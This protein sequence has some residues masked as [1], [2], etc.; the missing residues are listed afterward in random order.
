MDHGAPG[1]HTGWSRALRRGLKTGTGATFAVILLEMLVL[2]TLSTGKYYHL[3][4]AASAIL[5]GLVWLPL[6][7]K[8]V[9]GAVAIVF[10]I[11]IP[12]YFLGAKRA[13]SPE[14]HAGGDARRRWWILNALCALPLAIILASFEHSWDAGVSLGV[15]R[16]A[17]FLLTPLLWLGVAASWIGL[18]ALSSRAVSRWGAFLLLAGL[19]LTF[20]LDAGVASR[21][22]APLLPATLSL[23]RLLLSLWGIELLNFPS[24]IEGF[25]VVGTPGFQVEINPP[26]AG[27]QGILLSLILVGVCL[28]ALRPQVTISRL[29]V[30]LLASAAALYVLN[31]L[32]IALLIVIGSSYSPEVAVMGFH[33]NFGLVSAIVVSLVS[34][35]LLVPSSRN[36]ASASASAGIS[37]EIFSRE[38]LLRDVDFLVPLTLLL[39]TS[40]LTGLLTGSFNW[41]YPVSVTAATMGLFFIRSRVSAELGEGRLLAVIGG[42][43]AFVVWI[44]LIDDD[45][46]VS[47]AFQETIFSAPLWLA[48]PWLVVRILGSVVIVP[49]AEELA[50]RGFGM[51]AATLIFGS[52]LRGAWPSLAALLMTSAAYG[53]VHS[54]IVAATL[55]GLIYGGVRLW[56]GRVWDAVVAHAVSNTLL[57]FYVLV[58]SM[59]SYW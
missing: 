26:C 22:G 43:A 34:V 52:R 47:T 9:A 42:G 50:F 48:A 13:N 39:A 35:A 7:I 46:A 30:I 40:L 31:A 51:S 29:A 15:V 27:Y 45:A 12:R 11:E 8:A 2:A 16:L 49:L 5:R 24:S 59:W 23:V 10:M 44:M 20:L 38:G 14:V 57:S 17:L 6:P 18:A 56:T 54:Q 19:A 37:D 36:A 25:P 53:A 28:Y 58:F 41:L 1:W 55:V 3:S 4:T 21:V 33:T 32:R